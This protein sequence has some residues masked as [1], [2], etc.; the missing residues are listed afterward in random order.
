MTH[1]L[2]NNYTKEIIA[3]LRKFWDP[4]EISQPGDLAK[5]LR[6]PSEFDFR[7]Q[8]D[9]ITELPLDWGDS[10][11]EGTKPCMH[12]DPETGTVTPQETGSDL[13]LVVQESWVEA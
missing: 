12:Q 3:L 6:I 2:K 13:S 1:K 10:L 4:Q 7:D 11:L 8:W 9:L 5:A